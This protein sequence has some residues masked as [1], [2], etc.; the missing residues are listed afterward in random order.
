MLSLTRPE[1]IKE[2]HRQ[3]FLAGADI[4]ETNTF[5]GTSIAQAD[6]GLES[7]VYAINYEKFK[8]YLSSEFFFILLVLLFLFFSK[9]YPVFESFHFIYY[10]FIVSFYVN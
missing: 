9:Y 4:V 5:S 3:Y 1:I 10:A 7:A 8:D 6:Y 2:I